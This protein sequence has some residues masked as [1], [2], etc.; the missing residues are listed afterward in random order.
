MIDAG[1]V[2]GSASTTSRV[3]RAAG[4]LGRQEKSDT[5]ILRK[6]RPMDKVALCRILRKKMSININF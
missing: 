1:I 5:Q 3:L 2:Y 6:I 4:L